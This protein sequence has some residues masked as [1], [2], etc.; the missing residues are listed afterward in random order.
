MRLGGTALICTAICAEI[1]L[2]SPAVWPLPRS[3]AE[4]PEVYRDLQEGAVLDLPISV[5]N[6]ERGVYTYYQTVH[7]QPSPYGL[8]EPVPRR[9][10]QNRF[11]DFLLYLEVG[12][13]VSLP[14]S[15]PDLELVVGADLL[16]AQ[17]YRYIV[18]HE[19][20]YTRPKAQMIQTVLD[21]LFGPPR[22]YLQDGVAVYE[23]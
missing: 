4:V 23:I 12:R 14:R 10:R 1:L 18:M 8:N 16:K 19:K 22:E 9:L 21:S 13:S 2:A 6:L 5:P 7:G 20:L 11:T 17:G 15:L 3:E